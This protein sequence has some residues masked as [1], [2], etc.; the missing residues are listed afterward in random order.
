MGLVR[1][2]ALAAV[3]KKL[4]TRA[5]VC[6]V[7]RMKRIMG[8]LLSV[9]TLAWAAPGLYQ[10]MTAEERRA[11]GLEQLTAEQQAVLDA[12]AAR[13]ERKNLGLAG[14]TAK[15]ETRAVVQAEQNAKHEAEAGLRSTE[16]NPTV[17]RARIAGAFTGWTGH[18]VFTL[19]NGQ[20]WAQTDTR[21][22]VYTTGVKDTTVEISPTSSGG[23]KLR[24]TENGLGTSVK[25]R[26]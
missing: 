6:M 2:D 15:A 23:W 7:P 24:L 25:R 22:S 26:R 12:A 14:A 3:A 19:D 17:V 21:E 18:T 4:G 20:V 1:L 16:A 8:L 10:R 9:A 11:A 13:V 5:R